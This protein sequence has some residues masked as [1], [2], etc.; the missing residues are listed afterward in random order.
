MRAEEV[1]V[2]EEAV[3]TAEANLVL[4]QAQYA[5]AAALASK[6]FASGQTLDEST[7]SLAKA[8]ADLA[9]KQAMAAADKAGPIAEER[10]GTAPQ[11]PRSWDLSWRA[12]RRSRPLDCDRFA[13]TRTQRRCRV[14]LPGFGICLSYE[15]RARPRTI[16]NWNVELSSIP[17]LLRSIPKR[18]RIRECEDR[19]LARRARTPRIGKANTSLWCRASDSQSR[20]CSNVPRA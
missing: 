10:A 18:I 11:W 5:R 3:K 9:L 19:A 16:V 8:K 14:S 7:A 12:E 13:A 17:T 2:A 4:A 6:R 15:S 1:T 20:L